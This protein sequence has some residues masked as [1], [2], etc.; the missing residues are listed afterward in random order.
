MRP[1]QEPGGDRWSDGNAALDPARPAPPTTGWDAAPP[2]EAFDGTRAPAPVQ[3]YPPYP[4]YPPLARP[5]PPRRRRGRSALGDAFVALATFVASLILYGLA[6]GPDLGI[7]ITLILLVHELGHYI[8]VRAKGLPVGLPIFI[9]FLGAYVAIRGAPRNVRDEA[10]I[11]LAGPLVGGAAALAC[12]VAYG[13]SG[14]GVLLPLAYL[15]FA[16]NLI[17]LAPLS[18]LDGGRVARAFPAW[19]WL[20]VFLIAVG[21]SLY[22]GNLVALVA[23][24]VLGIQVFQSAG[25]ARSKS[26]YFKVPLTVRLSLLVAYIGLALALG[27]GL[28]ATHDAVIMH[29]PL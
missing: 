8:V 19:L 28:G 3:P 2:P 13:L 1:P 16:L 24:A 29:P 26:P 5:A 12:F 10:E 18:P 6:F 27:L 23:S 4:G 11:A 15:G 21:L 7:G 9:P 17:N 22:V 20:L 14:A 25:R